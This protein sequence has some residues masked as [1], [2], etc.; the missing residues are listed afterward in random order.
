M[1]VYKY[2]GYSYVTVA[3]IPYTEVDHVDFDV[4]AQPSET[5]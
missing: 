5:L 2:P 1:R 3:E 4:C